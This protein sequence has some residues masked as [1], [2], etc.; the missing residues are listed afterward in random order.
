[1]SSN[2]RNNVALKAIRGL[3]SELVN[4]YK[5]KY[6]SLA[7]YNRLVATASGSKV[8]VHVKKWREFMEESQKHLENTDTQ[9]FKFVY[10]DKLY[11]DFSEIMKNEKSATVVN[12]IWEHLL[13]INAVLDETPMGKE[14]LKRHKT[15]AE[16]EKKTRSK[17]NENFIGDAVKE[18]AQTME[19][20]NLNADDPMAT[21]MTLVSSPM[22]T[23]LVSNMKNKV[24]SGDL[25]IG[26]LMGT[27]SGMMNNLESGA[28]PSGVKAIEESAT[29]TSGLDD[30]E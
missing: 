30:V 16:E 25:D 2:R 20:A 6:H 24:E 22:F 9:D 10:N 21:I 13:T 28:R 29:D 5:N 1:M 7:L 19:N 11:V 17:D 14:L 12:T 15:K 18:I 3:C 8:D 27:V 4:L 26:S 23:S